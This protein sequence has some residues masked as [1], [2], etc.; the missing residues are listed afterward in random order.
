M[1]RTSVLLVLLKH[2]CVISFDPNN[3]GVVTQSP[4]VRNCT[5]FIP[6]SIGMRI[7]GSLRM[8]NNGVNGSMV[9]DSYT[10]YNL[11][12]IGVSITDKICTVGFDL[13]N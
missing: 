13:Y 3:V 10:Q 2:W 4:Y 5:N 7:D 12:G 8:G 9:V 11:N 6:N 1:L